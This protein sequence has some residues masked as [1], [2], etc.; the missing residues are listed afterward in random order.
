[1]QKANPRYPVYF[2]IYPREGIIIFAAENGHPV[3]SVDHVR[4]SSRIEQNSSKF[5]Q[6]KVL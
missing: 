3:L 2:I 4:G 5:R 6:I 1:M